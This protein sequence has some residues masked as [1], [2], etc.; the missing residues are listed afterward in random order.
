MEVVPSGSV[1]TRLEPEDGA[2]YVEP[3]RPSPLNFRSPEFVDVDLSGSYGRQKTEN[4]YQRPG[5]LIDFYGDGRTEKV[6][7]SAQFPPGL[8]ATPTV[9]APSLRGNYETDSATKGS[10][11]S[12][13]SNDR[14]TFYSRAN[15][16]SPSSS[17]GA[18]VYLW[19]ILP[20]TVLLIIGVAIGIY[21]ALRPKSEPKPAEIPFIVAS[22]VDK[23]QQFQ[24]SLENENSDLFK[25]F[26]SIYKSDISAALNSSYPSAVT[27]ESFAK[28]MVRLEMAEKLRQTDSRSLLPKV[29]VQ[30]HFMAEFVRSRPTSVNTVVTAV[31]S[32]A[33][34]HNKSWTPVAGYETPLVKPTHPP[35]TYY[36]YASGYFIDN[37]TNFNQFV[38]TYRYI[39]NITAAL[40]NTY[41]IHY[42]SYP[43]SVAYVNLKQFKVS[44]LMKTNVTFGLE[45]V[46]PN[47][48]HIPYVY[49]Q[50]ADT[51]LA[52]ADFKKF[53]WINATVFLTNTPLKQSTTPH[54][55]STT[56]KSLTTSNSKPYFQTTSL[57]PSSQS[58]PS[59]S[60]HSSVS[61]V[62]P[63][64][65]MTSNVSTKTTPEPSTTVSNSTVLTTPKNYSTTISAAITTASAGP[66]SS[67]TIANGYRFIILSFVDYDYSYVQPISSTLL[68]QYQN[69][70][71]AAL[72]ASKLYAVILGTVPSPHPGD[73]AIQVTL[74]VSFIGPFKNNLPYNASTVTNAI[75]TFARLHDLF[76]VDFAAYNISYT[77]PSTSTLAPKYKFAEGSFIDFN[78][79]FNGGSSKI[80]NYTKYVGDALF[81]AKIPGNASNMYITPELDG[82]TKFQFEILFIGGSA[83]FCFPNSTG[84]IKFA[85]QNYAKVHNLF[86]GTITVSNPSLTTPQIGSTSS[87]SMKPLHPS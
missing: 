38:P 76:W 40:N 75:K 60:T 82:M 22:F 30:V 10:R 44:T 32:W 28:S 84:V 64:S 35:I 68:S 65:P 55:S 9:H 80:G 56:V 31:S 25:K 26:A 13:I 6:N 17:P 59:N 43:V 39:G 66:G 4:F 51:L 34:S 49:H 61:T 15:G 77:T 63:Q 62:E 2:V 42:W 46:S 53:N 29:H 78:T 71:T 85:I 19:F 72:N 58:S 5:E 73:N 12:L 67:T 79:P 54:S 48:M 1:I 21:F 45:F 74:W 47:N 41:N 52:Y 27:I 23:S 87:S 18:F 3:L 83:P 86:W 33:K 81:A 36:K 57:L 11:K 50:I 20:V 69:N 8:A 37:G 16:K 70:V 7:R 24:I 14:E